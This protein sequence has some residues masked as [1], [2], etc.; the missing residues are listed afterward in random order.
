MTP[1]YFSSIEALLFEIGKIVFLS[2]K[3]LAK[4]YAVLIAARNTVLG[5]GKPCLDPFDTRT[6]V[7]YMTDTTDRPVC[8]EHVAL[9]HRDKVV[10]VG[11]QFDIH[12]YQ[13]L[14]FVG[15][16]ATDRSRLDIDV[17]RDLFGNYAIQ[18]LPKPFEDRRY[19]IDRESFPFMSRVY[20]YDTDLE[21]VLFIKTQLQFRP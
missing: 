1:A 12:G 13:N 17:V 2:G 11:N 8:F 10:L 15:R 20:W 14:D 6:L 16:T 18:T 21:N 4:I 19:C 3:D 7:R 9:A 5:S